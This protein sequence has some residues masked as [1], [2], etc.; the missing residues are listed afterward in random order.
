MS[1]IGPSQAQTAESSGLL[2]WLREGTPAA[3]RVLLAASL[4]WALDAFDVML[5]ALVLSALIM[6]LSLSTA[7]AGLLGSVTLVASG[8]GGIVFGTIADRAGRVRPR[9]RLAVLAQ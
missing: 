6:D 9:P 1:A 8:I 7:T 5:Y 3:R 4:G 2:G